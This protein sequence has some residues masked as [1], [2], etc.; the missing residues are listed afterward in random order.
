[1]GAT[2][3]D[4]AVNWCPW[5][6]SDPRPLPYQGSALPLSQKGKCTQRSANQRT[7]RTHPDRTNLGAGDGNRTRVISLEGWGSTIEL[8]PH[9]TNPESS[10]S[11]GSVRCHFIRF[12]GGGGWI[13]TSV[14]VSQQI[15]SLPPLATRAPLRRA[16]QYSEFLRVLSSPLRVFCIDAISVAQCCTATSVAAAS[17]P[18][19]T[20]APHRTRLDS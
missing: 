7:N 13:R 2:P 9:R 18:P 1:M 19:S 14:G 15:Y 4:G 20:H 17:M 16:S 11:D 12:A 10:T 8:L 6:E 5:R 3:K